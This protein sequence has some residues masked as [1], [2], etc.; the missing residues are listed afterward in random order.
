MTMERYEVDPWF[1]GRDVARGVLR[2]SPKPPKRSIFYHWRGI[3]N[4]CRLFSTHPWTM[5]LYQT[6][7]RRPPR[8]TG[9]A[10]NTVTRGCG[11]EPVTSA[12]RSEFM[13]QQLVLSIGVCQDSKSRR[14]ELNV[15]LSFSQAIFSGFLESL[16][17]FF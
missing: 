4:F 2:S 12:P 1:R 15:W 17:L 10:V 3:E 7:G 13:T 6:P 11:S 8:I 5:F 16:K 14:F 9:R